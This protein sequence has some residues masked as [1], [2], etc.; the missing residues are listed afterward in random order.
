[1]FRHYR[2]ILKGPVVNTLPSYTSISNAAVGSTIYNSDVSRRFYA[3]FL[4]IIEICW[5]EYKINKKIKQLHNFYIYYTIFV[6][7]ST[8]HFSHLQ[9]ATI[10]IDVSSVYGNLSY[11]T[12][13]LYIFV[14][15]EFIDDCQY[16]NRQIQ[17]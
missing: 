3:S 4:I 7:V 1:M 16:I 11:M 15:Q 10:L 17:C 5:S 12:S 13:R 14:E 8:I 2:T 9:G 6:H